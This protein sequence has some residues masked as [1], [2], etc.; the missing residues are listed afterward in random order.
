MY[1]N[2]D[3]FI[4][5]LQVTFCLSI[6]FLNFCYLYSYGCGIGRGVRPGLVRLGGK[7]RPKPHIA[8]L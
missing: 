4:R 2:L 5:D 3:V 7:S 1:V 8:V 6:T